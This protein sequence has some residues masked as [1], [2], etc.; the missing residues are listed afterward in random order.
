MTDSQNRRASSETVND[1]PIEFYEYLGDLLIDRGLTAKDLAERIGCDPSL[2]Q[3]WA[4]GRRVPSFANS[5]VRR[6]PDALELSLDEREMF[7]RTLKFSY[8]T[9][10]VQR[11]E[12]PIDPKKFEVI[13]HH[14]WRIAP[15]ALL[16][17]EFRKWWQS[18]GSTV[19]HQKD[20]GKEVTSDDNP[21]PTDS[22]EFFEG[23]EQS[24]RQQIRSDW[25]IG[26]GYSNVVRVA[27][28]PGPYSDRRMHWVAF[29][30]LVNL[31]GGIWSKVQRGRSLQA[32]FEKL[33]PKSV[34]ELWSG[35]D[36]QVTGKMIYMT[37]A[38][39]PFSRRL[40]Y[41]D[42][43]LEPWGSATL[44]IDRPDLEYLEYE[45]LLFVDVPTS[46]AVSTFDEARQLAEEWDPFPVV[47]V[48]RTS[49]VIPSVW[50]DSLLPPPGA[51]PEELTLELYPAGERQT[52]IET[53]I[54]I[55][56][57]ALRTDMLYPN[58]AAYD[59]TLFDSPLRS[60]GPWPVGFQKLS[61]IGGNPEPPFI[62]LGSRFG[63]MHTSERTVILRPSRHR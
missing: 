13:R 15:S 20:S 50:G 22:C 21:S 16:I 63:K 40:W 58:G 39:E 19:R 30:P 59:S 42:F 24:W 45:V 28:A 11:D 26:K 53:L 4:S 9:S 36:R 61:M 38:A 32:I 23:M 52:V 33:R 41:E 12:I 35:Y 10:L 1:T 48:V 6:I 51:G 34:I 5:I 56:V 44:R 43:E 17:D 54:N 29:D 47:A 3:H 7:D 37:D 57:L 18:R 8:L 46:Q 25:I 55:P 49:V 62:Y 60:D 14:W 2:T 31:T 27:G